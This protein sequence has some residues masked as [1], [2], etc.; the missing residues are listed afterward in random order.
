VH[1]HTT[2]PV[3][4]GAAGPPGGGAVTATVARHVA[5]ADPAETVAANPIHGADAARSAGY[6]DALVAGIHVYGW[7]TEAI[8]AAPELGPEW[9]DD[10]WADVRLRRPTYPGD[11]LTTTVADG[12]L[13]TAKADGTVV[14]EGEVGRG[15]APWYG[16]LERPRRLRPEPPVPAA[17]LRRMEL[18]RAP[19]G[20]D[21]RPMAVEASP[22]AVAA[23]VASHLGDDGPRWSERLHPAFLAGRM[24]PLFRHN[25]LYGPAI[26]VRSQVQHLG[27][28]RAGGE[29]V[30]AARLHAAYERKG[31]HYHESDCLMLGAD[32][33]EVAIKRHTGIF[34]VA[35]R[36]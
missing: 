7:A 30:V 32:G 24:T 36:S 27:P 21:Y 23:W 9:L 16:E 10:G 25:Y 13:V 14:L 15:R 29:L 8:L 5:T 31:H 2:T 17:E 1:A 3:L 34:K 26:H 4:P 6:A 11:E 35:A 12:R 19:V 28:A 22:G 33:A 20:E 18:A